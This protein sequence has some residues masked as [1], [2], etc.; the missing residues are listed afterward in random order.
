MKKN[1][2]D[3]AVRSIFLLALAVM[4]LL[5]ADV[6]F[7]AIEK[8]HLRSGTDLSAY[9]DSDNLRTEV[10]KAMRGNI[11]ASDGTVIAEDSRTY[12]IIC[13][14][15]SSRPSVGDTISYVQDKEGTAEQLSKILKIDYD[16]CLN[17]LNQD[18]YQTELGTAGRN[19]SESVKDE[20]EALNLPG[21]EFTNSIKR[22]YPL[23][24]FASNLIGF[25]QSDENGSV[26]GKMGA[27]LYLNSYLTGTDGYRTY[28]ADKNGYIL[29]GMKEDTQAAVNGNDVYTTLNV[30]IQQALE[31]SFQMTEDTFGAI[32]IW[33]AVM[34]ISTGKILAWGQYPS[35]DPN[36][37]DITDYNNY[38]SQL[39]YEP[40]STLKGITWSA[41]I[42]EGVY[43]GE[44][45]LYSGPFYYDW[46]E[47]RNPYR[48][49]YHKDFVITNASGNNWGW[50]TY[51]QGLMLSS[52]VAAAT[53]ETS[54]ITPD[55]LLEY[56]KKF[57]FFQPVRSDGMPEESG[58]L[59]FTWPGD[60]ISLS[61]GQG[62]TVT[63][64]Q[65]LQ[66]YSAI[67]G[68][69]TMKRPYYIES[70]RDG[71][72]SNKVLY[73]AST[74]VTGTPIT[75]DTA[76]QMQALLYQVVNNDTYGT[77]KYY[78]IDETEII[79][80]TGTTQVASNGNYLSGYTIASLMSAMPADNPQVLVY[81]CFEAPY[82]HDAHYK[83]DAVKN[84]LSRTAIELGFASNTSA[85][86]SSE[87]SAGDG[88]AV[89]VS[90]TMPNLVNHSLSYADE[91]LNG[92]DIT[93]YTL[94]NGD[95]VIAQYPEEGESLSNGERVFLV[96]DTNSFTMPDLTGWTRKDVTALWQ[97]TQFGFRLKGEGVV[98][99]QNIAAGTTVT[100]GTEIEVEFG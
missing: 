34:E 81:Y 29:P 50:I 67:F 25:A 52:N 78:K 90:G 55:I 74:K 45:T 15:D 32:R 22:V 28:Q 57:G 64:L 80:K 70:I 84:L 7:V 60:K 14:L 72:D 99:S 73:Q 35:F 42:N 4:I 92:L 23:G 100:K 37:L 5:A 76:K 21:I 58:Y 85:G 56:E 3:R 13:I 88:D 38:G 82:N 93:L 96:T 53:I 66:A 41:A 30:S 24:Q 11:Y 71:Y 62:S 65:M 2:G 1:R 69:G 59:Q 83:T 31:D 33:G 9:A 47:N 46:D 26:V 51:D 89:L 17:Y 61:Y 91:K 10:T 18:V 19:L 39:P 68:D 49:D 63:M 87:S 6:F 94:G 79:G 12:N 8:K 95:S 20:I 97:V 77:A 75:E 16:T 48:V 54:L 43:N 27:E 40:G 36:T 44:D 86:S 98:T